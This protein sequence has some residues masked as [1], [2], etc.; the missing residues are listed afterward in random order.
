MSATTFSWVRTAS[1]VVCAKML[2]M[3][4]AAISPEPFSIT[5]KTSCTKG[6]RHRCQAAPRKTCDRGHQPAVAVGDAQLDV[7]QATGPQRTQELRPERLRLAVTDHQPKNLAVTGGGDPGR[8]DHRLGHTPVVHPGLAVGRVQE[9]V[10]KDGV[11]Q[12]PL[13][14]RRQF[15]VDFSADPRHL[16]LRDPGVGAQRFDQ[17][18]HRAGQ[19]PVHVCRHHHGEQRSADPPTPLEQRGEERPAHTLGI[20]RSRSPAWV[21]SN[22][23]RCLLRK[24]VRRSECSPK[25]APMTS[26]ASASMSS[27]RM[28]PA[29]R[30]DHL[31]P[32]GRT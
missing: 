5:A 29:Q 24:V 4:A 7:V 28:P 20:F 23:S 11:V 2:R 16:G 30:P 10:G 15:A 31:N 26:I 14:E 3:V 1:A 27:C 22:R 19:D 25:A 9:D 8:D 32:V 12:R 17:V 13:L 6:T 18:I 21:V